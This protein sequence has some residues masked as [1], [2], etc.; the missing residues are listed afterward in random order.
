MPIQHLSI[1]VPWHDNAWNGTI[2]N[3]PS[4]NADC[5]ILPL[6]RE[7]RDDTAENEHAGERISGF[8]DQNFPACLRERGGFMS[9]FEYTRNITHPYVS[10]SSAH[11]HFAPTR[12]RYPAFSAACTPFQWTRKRSAEHIADEKGIGLNL[13]LEDEATRLMDGFDSIWLQDKENHLA[14]LDTFFDAVEPEKSLCFFYAK[15]T[16]LSDD[17]RRVI[18][19][20]GRV[21]HVGPAVEYS[22][23]AG[24]ELR[25]MIWERSVQHSIRDG[26]EDGFLLPYHQVLDL[27]PQNPDL[28]TSGFVAFAPEGSW[29]E[30]SY[31]SEHVSHDTAIS[32]LLA[33]ADA[34]KAAQGVVEGDWETPLSWID[35]RLNELW[36]MRGPYPSLGAALRAFGLEHGNFIAYDIASEMEDNEDPWS[37]VEQAFE[38]P[39]L[40]EMDLG[41]YIGQ[42]MREKWKVLPEKRRTLLKLISR[43]DLTAEQATRFY[44]KTER[45]K[46]GIVTEHADLIANPYLLYELDRSS[47]D[48]IAFGTIDRGVFPDA[49][50]RQTHPLPEPSSLKDNSMDGRR[51]RALMVSVLEQASLEGSTLL[52]QDT[53]VQIIRDMPLQPPCPVDE[54]LMPV[55]EQMFS[56]MIESVEMAEGQPAYQLSRLSEMGRII[57][58]TVEQRISWRR[59]EVEAD[60]Q[61]LLDDKLED[62][63]PEDAEAE[64]LA[65]EEKVEALKELAASQVSVLI[66][67]AGTGKTTL[68]SVLCEHEKVAQG[69]ITLLAPTGKARVQLTQNTGLPAQTIAQFL[70]PSKRYHPQIGTYQLSGQ[71]PVQVGRT[72]VIDEASMLTE[73]QLAAVLDAVTGVAR[74]ILVGDPRQLPPIGSGRPFVDI[75]ARLQ[76]EDIE[77]Q[78][79]RVGRGYAELT[80]RRRQVGTARDDLLLAE[81]FSGQNPGAGADEIWNRVGSGTQSETLRFV[82]WQH[83]DELH[84]QLLNVLTEELGLDG[85][86]DVAGFEQSIGGRPPNDKGHI[87]FNAG[88]YGK[89]GAAAKVE[90]WQIL[91]PVRGQPHG[92]WDINRIVQQRFRETTL[93]WANSK[94]RLIPKPM[95]PENIVYGDKV[96][97]TSNKRYYEGQVWPK[98]GSLY[99]AANGEIGSV[100]GQ[101]KS[102]NMRKLPK[103]LKVEFSS[104]QGYTYDFYSSDFKEDANVR[105]E[106][107]YAITVH[108]AQGSEF[109][110]TLLILPSHTI[111]GKELLYTALTRQ[112]NKVVI[113]HQGDIGELRRHAAPGRSDIASRLTNLFSAPS[114]VDV[115]GTFLEQNL[116]HRTQRGEAVRS[117]SEVI[118]ANLLYNEIYRNGRGD[119]A[120]EKPL[121]SGDSVRY[122]DFTVDDSAS[123]TRF[124]W[125]HLGMM[126]NPEYRARWDRKLEWYREQGI[127]PHTEGGG[128]EGTLVITRDDEKGGINSAELERLVGEVFG[129]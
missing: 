34:L 16:P 63:A 71:D 45:K 85:L 61:D 28:D 92:V 98:Q 104:Q 128:P 129:L 125:E 67:P 110:L 36:Q 75:V 124:Y 14:M 30:Y 72:I 69:G 56:P 90:N 121:I 32:S 31:G 50:V 19:G 122:P 51:V 40:L 81:W 52:S 80:V 22:Y 55:V 7:K 100:V 41:K 39:G 114:L 76:P 115:G 3:K 60:W 96:I 18:V 118:I 33:C 17:P 127:R 20:V 53:V 83:G 26:F 84:E 29:E 11:Q 12:F 68:L 24:G 54:D 78:F 73:E 59:H 116:I 102:A 82:S 42:T 15:R 38:D 109:D 123:G 13:E 44:Q 47:L 21:T 49:V 77:G 112:R 101:F 120:Y 119:Y 65:R 105:L 91:S 70:L 79:P 6:I 57:R 87:Y 108:K 95:G 48:A 111:L 43:F 106:L 8:E 113:L 4:E 88:W 27:A 107:A 117:K 94:S 2:C 37:Y 99:Y 58:H 66:G 9:P 103:I 23:R 64:R 46:A 35:A 74:L 25:S 1:R 62:P 93:E 86:R 97:N 126:H 10:F 89:Q 5:L